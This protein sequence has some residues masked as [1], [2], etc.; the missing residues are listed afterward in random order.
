MV[1][2]VQDALDARGIDDQVAFAGQFNPRGHTG[3][4][5]A[6]GLVGGDAGGVIGGVAE[7]VGVAAGSLAGGR[8]ADATSGLPAK[9]LVAVSETMVYGFACGDPAQ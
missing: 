7:G 9:M 6:G 1:E 3:G 8:A 2:L 4:M 5:F